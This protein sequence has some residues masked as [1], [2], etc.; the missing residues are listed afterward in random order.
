M[1]DVRDIF[2]RILD[3]PAPPLVSAAEAIASGRRARHRRIRTVALA[4]TAALTA[5]AVGIPGIV[6]RQGAPARLVATPDPA[7]AI[8]RMSTVLMGALPHSGVMTFGQRAG[9]ADNDS[10]AVS[11]N[12]YIGGKGGQLVAFSGVTPQGTPPNDLCTIPPD[13]RLLPPTEITCKTIVLNGFR[14]RL[15]TSTKEVPARGGGTAMVTIRH[16]TRYA[17][18]RVYIVEEVPMVNDYM[19]INP[20]VPM[21]TNP[22][23]SDAQLERLV[24]SPGF[25][26]R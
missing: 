2:D 17:D 21:L 6:A 13:S 8:D 25:L 23:L 15:G 11:T 3:T 18:G 1:S 14:V 9:E 24:T 26:P 4:G 16:A 12:I 10:V 20:P 22:A 5:L 7:Q 19:E